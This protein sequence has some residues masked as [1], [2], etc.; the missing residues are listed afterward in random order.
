MDPVGGQ[1]VV[2]GAGMA[3]LLAARVVA[4]AYDRVTVL[5][6]DRLPAVGEP[7]KGVP[8]DRHVHLLLPRG[9]EVLEKLFPGLID[10][11]AQAGAPTC[12]LFAQARFA[13]SGHFL[14]RVDTGV[15]ALHASRPFLEG[16]VR[17]RVRRLAN[18][19]VV[20]GCEVVGLRTSEDRSRVTGVH[21]RPVGTQGDDLWGADLV[22]DAAGRGGRSCAW[23]EELGYR[24][25]PEET[26]RIGVGYA[27]C[28]LRLDSKALGG[29]RLIGVG[30]E[31][32]RPT[33]MA[34]SAIEGERWILTLFGYG[35]RRPPADPEGFRTFASEVA[36]PDVFAAMRDV[37]LPERIATHRLES[38]QRRRYERLRRFPVG[39]LVVGDALCSFNPVYGQG[40][41]VA[42]L[43]AEALRRFLEAGDPR[44]AGRFFR[45]A[46]R[47]VDHAWKM[48][49]GA[50][51]ALPE[52]QGDRSVQVRVVNAY[53]R[54]LLRAAEADP[55]VVIAFMRVTGMTD[56]LPRLLHPPI[57]A[58]VLLGIGRKRANERGAQREVRIG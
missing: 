53:M 35:P 57:A 38:N 21:V 55:M 51:L 22:V 49:V 1:A 47:S 58:R 2:V 46:A 48:A 5:E 42:A 16:H 20:E 15:R 32:G 41:T 31:P 52:V 23:M 25:P 7:R 6:R 40:M 18:V 37:E 4:E 56:P 14:A 54:R 19:E 28:R 3:G 33:G 27:S 30:P 36:P 45:E 50:D 44:S 17:E 9:Q 24:P 13:P 12:D 11:L 39:L 29:D 43:E 26:V 34:L 10:Q 8:Q